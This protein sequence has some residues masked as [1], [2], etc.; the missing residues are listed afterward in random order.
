[1]L[2]HYYLLSLLCLLAVV[3]PLHRAYSVDAW[4]RPAIRANAFPSW[5][6]YLLR[7]QVAVVYFYAGLAKLGED[8]LLHAQPLKIWLASRGDTPVLPCLTGVK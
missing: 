3:L 7:F 8:W 1:M 2:N 6:T 4:R 5:F